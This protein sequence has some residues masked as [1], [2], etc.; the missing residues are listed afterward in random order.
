ME[1]IRIVEVISMIGVHEFFDE[2][3]ISGVI[4]LILFDLIS[5]LP[6]AYC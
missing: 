3:K 1:V 4:E 2:Y 6:I 5:P